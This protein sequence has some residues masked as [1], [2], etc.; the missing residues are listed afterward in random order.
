LYDSS[1]L[2][3][4]VNKLQ[5][6][7]TS[8]IKLEKTD[9]CEKLM[10]AIDA[11]RSRLGARATI[12]ASRCSQ[13]HVMANEML[14]D[15]FSNIVWDCI[16]TSTGDN[17]INISMSR[18]TRDSKPQCIILI[19]N[20]GTGMPDEQKTRLFE[21]P[22]KGMKR[23]GGRGIGLYLAKSIIDRFKGTFR[24]EDLEPGDYTRGTR[25]IIELPACE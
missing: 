9:V 22:G 6:I 2:I 19:D 12:N 18:Q 15:A 4:D 3:T 11:Y 24:V 5:R 25:F 16:K 7:T 17:V 14:F 21:R 10:D 1:R 13:C 23:T 20:R 8:E